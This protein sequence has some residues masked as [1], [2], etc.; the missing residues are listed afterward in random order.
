MAKFTGFKIGYKIKALRES[1]NLTQ[2]QLA[3]LM[4]CNFKTIGNLENDRTVPDLRQIIN[5]CSVLKIS[6]DA[7]FADILVPDDG[8]GSDS[9][10]EKQKAGVLGLKLYQL[11]RNELNIVEALI[12][13]LVKNR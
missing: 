1:N 2:E 3:D 5:L 10:I 9:Q 8:F 11:S 6:M 12:D 4:N 13:S 7:L